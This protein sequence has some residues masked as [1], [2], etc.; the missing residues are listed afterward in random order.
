MRLVQWACLVILSLAS[1]TIA[2]PIY[3]DPASHLHDENEP[4]PGYGLKE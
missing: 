1:M 3:F 2:A 4:G